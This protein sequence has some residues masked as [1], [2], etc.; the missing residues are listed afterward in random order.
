M[1]KLIRYP[2]SSGAYFITCVT[3]NRMPLLVENFALLKKAAIR[4][5]RQRPIKLEAYSILPDHLHAL[6]S[7]GDNDISDIVH[8]FKTSYSAQF[9]KKYGTKRVWQ[10]RFWDHIIRDQEDWNC[11]LSYIHYNPAKHGYIKDP[12]FWHYSSISRYMEYY[13]A[14]W[15]VLEEMKFPDNGFGE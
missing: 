13:S 8:R 15:G 14:D 5:I 7:I 4:L 12:K 3:H 6:I 9:Y 1:S 10:K 2:N 11:H